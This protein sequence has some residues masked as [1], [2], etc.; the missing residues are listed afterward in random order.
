MKN[1]FVPTD[2]SDCAD[3]ALEVAAYLA[4]KFDAEIMLYHHCN[5]PLTDSNIPGP[6]LKEMMDELQKRGEEESSIRSSVLQ[7]EGIKHRTIVDGNLL[8]IDSMVKK[9]AEV[10]ADL[11]VAGTTGI[12]GFAERLIGSNA[13]KVLRKS[14]CDVLL[15]PVQASIDFSGI[16]F[17]FDFEANDLPA[18]LKIAALGEKMSIPVH[19]VHVET[20]KE[21]SRKDRL[22]FEKFKEEVGETCT[23]KDLTFNMLES[24]R[25]VSS[26]EEYARKH[27]LNVIALTA[28]EK[29]FLTRLW[30]SS[31]SEKLAWHAE[32]LVYSVRVH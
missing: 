8:F 7:N 9:I 25:I 24:T 13:E 4:K 23:Y 18:V 1:I 10:N 29:S 17:G 31:V 3:R 27:N 5:L 21:I 32:T 16:L 30:H 19:V 20:D 22:A 6:V 12:S 2:F 11:V 15:V 28:R 26:L 14:P